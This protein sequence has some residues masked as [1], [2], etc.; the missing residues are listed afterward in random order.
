MSLLGRCGSLAR[1]G[2]AA[3][4]TSTDPIVANEYQI[5]CLTCL[6][7]YIR[8]PGLA[9][10]E[11]ACCAVK[12]SIRCNADDGFDMSARCQFLRVT[13]KTRASIPEEN[14]HKRKPLNKELGSS[15]MYLPDEV[16]LI[17]LKGA[18]VDAL[19]GKHVL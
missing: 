7:H 1:R 9:S 17:S 8:E 4:C 18:L 16:D 10:E 6:Q 3:V 13:N 5:R 12:L 14:K 19:E 2:T 15:A 11:E